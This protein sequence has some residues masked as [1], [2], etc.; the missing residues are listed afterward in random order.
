MKEIL[1]IMISIIALGCQDDKY[2]DC[3]QNTD[4]D[5]ITFDCTPPVIPV[6][7][8]KTLKEYILRNQNTDAHVYYM[9]LCQGGMAYIFIREYRRFALTAKIDSTDRLPMRCK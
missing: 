8:K 1:I 6:K 3:I 4:G 5:V 9:E 7:P 2:K